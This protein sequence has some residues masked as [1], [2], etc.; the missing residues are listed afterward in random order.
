MVVIILKHELMLVFHLQFSCS[1]LEED[2]SAVNCEFWVGLDFKICTGVDS[3]DIYLQ[4]GNILGIS[5]T[6]S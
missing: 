5:N 2:F 4:F 6:S 1:Y 3:H